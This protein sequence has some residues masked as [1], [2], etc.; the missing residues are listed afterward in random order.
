MWLAS[1]HWSHIRATSETALTRQPHM[2]HVMCSCR[3]QVARIAPTTQCYCLASIKS[4]MRHSAIP[5]SLSLQLKTKHYAESDGGSDIKVSLSCCMWL[6]MIWILIAACPGSVCVLCSKVI[7]SFGGINLL[8]LCLPVC[9][10]IYL[11]TYLS[12]HPFTY[13]FMLSPSF[14]TTSLTD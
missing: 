5:W 6:T 13:L 12:I 9:L 4:I 14:N 3:P 8:C 11:S 10:C 1:D 7:K 2:P